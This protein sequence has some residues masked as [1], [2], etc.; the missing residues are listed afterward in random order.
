M[1][2][3]QAGFQQER[4]SSMSKKR[5]NTRNQSDE[6]VSAD[7]I[8][9][10]A[11]DAFGDEGA[12]FA[13]HV[14]ELDDFGQFASTMALLGISRCGDERGA[15]DEVR[16]PA[17]ANAA[18]VMR[19]PFL[20]I[21]YSGW[22]DGEEPENF[23]HTWYDDIPCGWASRFGLELCEDVRSVLEASDGSGQAVEK[24]RI[25]QIKEKFGTLRWYDGGAWDEPTGNAL[26]DLNVLYEHLSALTCIE[27]GDISDV[28]MTTGGW[29]SPECYRCMR[30]T[31]R[32]E[33]VNVF[34]EQHGFKKKW[35]PFELADKIS[36]ML[37]LGSCVQDEPDL[38][39]VFCTHYSKDAEKKYFPYERLAAEHP[40]LQVFRLAGL[41]K[42][43]A[44]S[45]PV[46]TVEEI[47]EL[48]AE[49]N[50]KQ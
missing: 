5:F 19:Y 9:K 33:V 27:C 24:Y 12:R 17:F 20:L 41:Y 10:L 43:H 35:V 4:R 31:S 7:D 2:K 1:K 26:Y 28:W 23:K 30:G 14:A 45:K 47:E 34:A 48:I 49:E 6:K 32:D 11:V 25:D 38:E 44:G 29:I 15:Q 22:N 39:K 36:R 3:P 13:A 46:S 21:P 42:E 16:P 18:L 37:T 40:D 50:A 8:Y